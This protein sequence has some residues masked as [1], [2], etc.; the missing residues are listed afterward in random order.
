MKP[1]I[2]GKNDV[3]S[4]IF[5]IIVGGGMFSPSLFSS[6]EREEEPEVF[7]AV[8]IE[9][10]FIGSDAEQELL[11]LK[12]LYKPY[13]VELE[14]ELANQEGTTALPDESTEQSLI[15]D[16]DGYQLLA[17]FDNGQAIALVMHKDRSG[18]LLDLLKLKEGE[19]L[20]TYKVTR[21]NRTSIEFT[22]QV[23]GNT[24][25]LKLFKREVEQVDE[26]QNNE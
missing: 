26:Q 20:L 13:D 14:P 9:H 22:E 15:V 25:Q 11:S 19:S 17:T 5:G 18:K 8:V 23:S 1:F 3:I 7:Q 24:V 12:S 21:I 6:D 10:D 2:L 4:V 16:S